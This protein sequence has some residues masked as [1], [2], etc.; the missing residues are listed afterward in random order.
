MGA[1]SMALFARVGGGIFTKAAMWA[2]TW[3]VK[4]RQVFPK[5]I[6]ETCSHRRQ[7]RRQCRRC[8]RHGADLYE[9][10]VGSIVALQHWAWQRARSAGRYRAYGYGSSR[11]H[12]I[13]SH[14][15]VLCAQQGERLPSP[16]FGGFT[17]RL[18]TSSFIVAVFRYFLGQIHPGC[19]A[20]WA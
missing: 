4:S 19:R 9:S 5:T 8:R 20:I 2:Q 15:H 1:S 12:R 7:C 3:W 10:Y 6:P 14:R 18:F 17:Q 16:C 13:S 11:R